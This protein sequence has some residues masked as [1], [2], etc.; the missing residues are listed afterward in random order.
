VALI[1]FLAF[2]SNVVAV[3]AQLQ[4]PRTFTLHDMQARAEA[5]QVEGQ[6][7]LAKA[8]LTGT[9]LPRDRVMAYFWFNLAAAKG[10]SSG[11]EKAY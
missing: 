4:D 11:T 8:Y 10:T 2:R 1:T 7:E 5:G 9:L 6:L 3:E